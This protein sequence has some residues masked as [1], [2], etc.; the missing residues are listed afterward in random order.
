MSENDPHAGMREV[1]F[2]D[3]PLEAWPAGRDATGEP[4]SSFIEARDHLAQ[5]RRAEA[6]AAWRRITG[7]RT[8]ES[9]HYLQAWHALRSI[10]EPA[11]AEVGKK[12]LGVVIEMPVESGVDI[13]AAYADGSARYLNYTGASILWDHPDQS[14][15]REVDA[16]LSAGGAVVARIGPWQGPRP[17][18]AGPGEARLSFL[19]PSGL[20]FGQGPA[21][22]LMGDALG[23]PVIRAGIAL[24]QGLVSKQQRA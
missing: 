11:P 21:G 19:T 3:A 17:G 24:M 2:G 23:G 13:L 7:I 22:A 12:V 1:L 4:W 10:G 8:L 18:P 14:F 6:A 16:V 20:H 15:E 9:R 5:G